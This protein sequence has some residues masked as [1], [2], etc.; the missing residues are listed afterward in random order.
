MS[1]LWLFVCQFE[2]AWQ[3]PCKSRRLKH[4]AR[5]KKSQSQFEYKVSILTDMLRC[6]PWNRL[7]LT[8]RW[9][10]QEYQLN[11]DPLRLPPVHM[12]T[13]YGPVVSKTVAASQEVV[14]TVDRQLVC[15]VCQCHIQVGGP[16][17]S[18]IKPC[19]H[20]WSSRGLL[21]Y[22]TFRNQCYCLP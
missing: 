16:S 19:P 14:D 8:V 22:H 4:I 17:H 7:P 15:A 9:L 6:G 5:K 10:K 13:A 11:F 3:K 1:I 12:P 2:W 20:L 21:I 18:C